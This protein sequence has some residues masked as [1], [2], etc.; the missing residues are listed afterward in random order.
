MATAVTIKPSSFRS[1]STSSS[2]PASQPM[3]SR[4]SRGVEPLLRPRPTLTTVVPNGTGETLK[5]ASSAV[6]GV[7]GTTISPAPSN[8]DPSTC[9]ACYRRKSRCAMNETVNKC[10]SCDFHRQECTFTLSSQLGKRKLDEI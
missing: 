4:P 9:D 8:R 1:Q 5:T 2:R 7:V 6:P 10:Y 3:Q